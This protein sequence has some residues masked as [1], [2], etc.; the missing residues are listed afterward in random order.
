MPDLEFAYNLRELNMNN[1][2]LE[3]FNLNLQN[4]TKLEVVEVGSNRFN[5]TLRSGWAR[6]QGLK[7][8]DLSLNQFFGTLPAD[9]GNTSNLEYINL[10]GNEFRGRV[11]DSLGSLTKLK[12][13]DLRRNKFTHLPD[14]ILPVLKAA[15]NYNH[16]R[17]GDS[18]CAPWHPPLHLSCT[19]MH[20]AFILM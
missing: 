1:N 16:T 14:S 13:L 17:F 3:G 8:L 2:R 5:G 11:P 18:L 19:P 15:F 9:I 7:F 4:L 10:Y 6:N 20:Y 12:G